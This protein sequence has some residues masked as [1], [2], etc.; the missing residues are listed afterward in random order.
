MK[1]GDVFVIVIAV[2]LAVAWMLISH[3]GSVAAIY[4][5]GE[6]YKRIPLSEDSE[7]VVESEYGTNTVV[8]KDGEVSVVDASCDG[9]DCEAETI[10]E[11]AHSIV[12]L[13]NRLCIMIEKAKTENETDVIV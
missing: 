8:I 10:S 5:D 13:P 3:E 6:L 11:T 7:V 9:K 4:V 12:C 2:V 1:K